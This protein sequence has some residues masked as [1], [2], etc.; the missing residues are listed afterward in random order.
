MGPEGKLPHMNP[1]QFT[2]KV[3]PS[4]DGYGDYQQYRENVELWDAMTSIAPERRAPTVIGQLTGQAQVTAK[5]LP[6]TVLT[7]ETGITSLL[8]EMDKKFGLDS[9]TLLHNNIS[10]FFDYNWDKHMTV[11]EFVVG[12]HSRL[13]KV[14]KLDMN[15][16]LKGHLLLKQANLDSH[17]RNLVVGAAGGDYTLQALATSLRNAFR[18]QAPPHVSMNTNKPGYRYSSAFLRSPDNAPSN[19]ITTVQN[20]SPSSSSESPMFFT[21]MSV[22]FVNDVPSAIVDSGSCC[23]VVGQN[24]LDQAMKRLGISELKDEDICQR[25]HLF[26]PSNKPMKTICA[27]RVPFTCNIAQNN[28]SV[29][30]N[31]RFDVIEGDLPFLIGLPSLLAMKGTL[32]FQ[33]CNL[34]LI[35]QRTTY[36][37]QLVKRSSHLELPLICNV[38]HQRP[39]RDVNDLSPSSDASKHGPPRSNIRNN[40]YTPV[41]E[42]TLVSLNP[43]TLLTKSDLEKVHA[44]LGHATATKMKAFIREAHQWDPSYSNTID[45]IV[46]NCN[47]S[48]ASNPLPRPVC[49]TSSTPLQSESNISIDVVFFNKKPFLHII[50]DRTKWSEVGLLRTRRLSDQIDLLKRIQFHRHGLPNVIR[51]DQEYNKPQFLGFCMSL[52]IQFAPV[53]ANHHEG[54]ALVERANRSIREHVNRIALAEPR[55]SLVQLVSAATYHKNTTRGHNK[56]SSFELL[57]GR[58]PRLSSVCNPSQHGII[59]G[60]I[61]DRRRRQLQAAL[62]SNIRKSSS[63][64][65]GDSVFFWRDQRGWVGP[66]LVVDH[67]GSTVMIEHGGMIKS[68]DA[69]RVRV[70][71]QQ[72]GKHEIESSDDENERDAIDL[73]N[74]QGEPRPAESAHEATPKTGRVRRTQAQ[75]LIDENRELM[76]NIP[77]KRVTTQERAHMVT[78]TECNGKVTAESRLSNEE[79]ITSYAKE[80]ESWVSNNAYARVSRAEVPRCAN[81]IGSHVV[82][83]RKADGTPKARIVP[84]GH[85]D[86]EKNNVRGDA[87]A[88]NI[89]SM[90]LLLSIAAEHRWKVYKM[91]VKSAYLQAKGFGRNIYV[92]PP[93][94]ENDST[95]LWKLLVPAYGLTDSGRLWYLTSYE[96]LTKQFGFQQ[97]KL[98]PSMYLR[99]MKD[100]MLLLVVQVDDYL[101]AGPKELTSKFEEFLHKQFLIGSTECGT[102]S[103]MG[104]RFVQEETGKI[105][106]NAK[107]KLDQVQPIIIRAA[108]KERDRNANESEI[109]SYRS[110]IGKL[111]YIGRLV[112]PTIAFHA[113]NAATKC[114]GLR[115]HHLRALNAT[116]RAIKNFPCVITFIP[117]NTRTYKLE[118][119]SDASMQSHEEKS[120]VRQGI[121]IFR[122][123]GDIVHPIAWLSRLARRVARST[124]TAELLAA[125]DAVDR[126][127]YLKHLLEES[128]GPQK[129]E[130]VLDS[131]SAVCLCSTT[132]EPEEVKN[133]LLLASIREEFNVTSMDTIRWTPG[134]THLADALTKDNQTISKLLNAVLE[135]GTHSHPTESYTVI[136][137]VQVPTEIVHDNSENLITSAQSESFNNDAVTESSD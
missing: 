55:Q 89:D 59:D 79:K 95:G 77:E 116:L 23:S 9:V 131:R 135:S 106:L 16:E 3:P 18:C 56:A 132:K 78:L 130:L 14:S 63:V 70:A 85:R 126:V 99:N 29:L 67:R 110:L 124:S 72:Q 10:D 35:I 26:G 41:S 33:Y 119:M 118:A 15:D 46:N 13:D 47:C 96:V 45:Q 134:Q 69:H 93:R 73:H 64:Q 44:Q 37:L 21:H 105:T 108:S 125:A 65:V 88:I 4:F 112:C 102:F 8:K 103:I 36:R 57:Y 100:S 128:A 123:S 17:D 54:N 68:A 7:S 51:G 104:I 87:P 74:L 113:S 11:E 122:R 31:I 22:D 34:S 133:K 80:K 5:T 107:E 81:I 39:H 19:G 71:P 32:N 58:S 66:G 115:L 27:V 1:L 53:A 91:D 111:L 49:S 127:T 137:D 120:N 12:F 114:D 24:T 38:T 28:S 97:S 76:E 48:L 86:I 20:G 50:D 61:K 25:E 6:L 62:H 75:I 92:R 121:L 40:Y 42:S 60:N 84:W 117:G 43:T 2:D 109:T 52:D 129:T 90:R 101:Y 136:S 82:Y 83:R 30:F 94:E 98:D